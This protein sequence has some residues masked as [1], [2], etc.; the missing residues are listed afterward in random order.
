MKTKLIG[1]LFL[2]TT[3]ASLAS[4]ASAREVYF[5]G[6]RLDG[7]VRLKNQAFKG[8]DVKFDK[9]GNVWITVKGV[10]VS[11]A[12][13]KPVAAKAS[14]AAPGKVTKQYWLVIPQAN[15]KH[16]QYELNVYL[17]N[18]WLQ[19]IRPGDARG[20]MDITKRVQPGANKVRVVARKKIGDKRLSS[21]PKDRVQII[22]GEGTAGGG[23]VMINRPLLTYE[24]TAAETADFSDDFVF[25]SR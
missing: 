16:V 22:I 3:W 5:N 9:D 19:R 20:V 6:V 2:L 13:G 17:N 23:T 8:C 1:L 25:N 14:P 15:S 11:L 10:K 24:R 21:S 7:S 18:R 4:S 12:G